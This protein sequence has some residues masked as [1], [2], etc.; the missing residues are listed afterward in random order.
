MSQFGLL[1]VTAEALDRLHIPFMISGSHAS[2]LQGE[3]RMTHD[4]DV[5][6]DVSGDQVDALLAEFP[7]P[8]Y[9]ASRE[10]VDQAVAMRGMFNVI[11]LRAGDKIDFWMLTDD[12]FDRSR[13]GRR[14]RIDLDGV[15]VAM[16]SPEDT[17]IM[18]L[19]WGRDAGGSERHF[20]DALRVYEIQHAILDFGYLDHWIRVLGLT[21]DWSRLAVGAKPL[22]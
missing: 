4:I 12:A 15:S 5:V 9:Y 11:D 1:K 6:V 18:K 20:R 2:S 10:A 13:F 21:K 3:P 7:S 16:S 19:R 17:I 14:Q 22:D 8:A